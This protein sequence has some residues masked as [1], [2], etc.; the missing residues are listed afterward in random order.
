MLISVN[1]IYSGCN[2]CKK[3][4]NNGDKSSSKTNSTGKPDTKNQC[5]GL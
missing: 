1:F 3:K 2:N 5:L 4:G